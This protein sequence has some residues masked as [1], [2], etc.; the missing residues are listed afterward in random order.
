M[1]D[2]DLR[3]DHACIIRAAGG[4]VAYNGFHM[5]GQAFVCYRTVVLS[6][7]LSVILVYCSQTVGW[8]KMKLRMEVCL[9]PGHIALDLDPAPLPRGT[10]PNF[11]PSVVAKQLYGSRCHLVRR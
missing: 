5:N 1:T 9:G 11:G 6:V 7:C 2:Q 8:I 3:S 10:A 4:R